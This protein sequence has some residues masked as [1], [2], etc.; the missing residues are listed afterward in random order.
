MTTE[1]CPSA[2]GCDRP[3]RRSPRRP[4]RPRRSA[5]AVATAADPRP[6]GPELRLPACFGPLEV[7]YDLDVGP[8]PLVTRDDDRRAGPPASGATCEL[9]PVTRRPGARPARSARTPLVPARA[10][11]RG[12]RRRPALAQGRHPQP[13]PLVQGPRGRHAAAARPWRSASRRSPAR[14]PATSPGRRPRPRRRSACRPTSSSPR[15]L[16]PAKIDHA[17]AY[18]ATVVPRRRHVRRR[19]PPVPRGRRRARLGR[20]STSTSAR[21]T[22]RAARRSPTRS[23]SRSAGGCPTSSSRPIASGAMFTKLARALR[24]AGRRSAGSSAK[25]VRFVGGQAAGCAPVATAFATATDAHRSRYARPTR[26]CARSRSATRPTAATRSSSSGRPAAARSRRSPTRR[27]PR[28][29]AARR[30]SRGSTRR[31][32]AA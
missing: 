3:D 2:A 25:D 31:P 5:C 19:E 24:R 22:P 13:D 12:A 9:L 30:A 6:T 28:R 11:G 32:R 27:P 29:S 26:S 17:L 21:S 15:D 14:S 20:S 7:A 18:G 8:R 16:E 10:P 23:R 1:R 4:V